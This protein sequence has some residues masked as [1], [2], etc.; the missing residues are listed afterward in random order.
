MR[1]AWPYRA[2]ARASQPRRRHIKP[3]FEPIQ[4]GAP[5]DPVA[6][7]LQPVAQICCT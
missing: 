6:Q 4:V 5:A 1:G 3:L 2:E 7:V